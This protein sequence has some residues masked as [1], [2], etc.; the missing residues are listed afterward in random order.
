MAKSVTYVKGAELPPLTVQFLDDN[1]AGPWSS[2]QV[3]LLNSKFG[4]NDIYGGW[5]HPWSNKSPQSATDFYFHVSSF[6]PYSTY[7]LKTTI[8]TS[9]NT[10]NFFQ[11]FGAG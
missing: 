4:T 11:L 6:A 1:N 7:L 2:A 10:G 3:L 9:D 5:I 8:A